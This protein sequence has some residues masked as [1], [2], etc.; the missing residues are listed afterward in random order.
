MTEQYKRDPGDVKDLTRDTRYRTEETERI[1]M[2]D[3]EMYYNM[4]GT[5]LDL[6]EAQ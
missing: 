1:N 2:R 4:E 3:R 5:R 6:M